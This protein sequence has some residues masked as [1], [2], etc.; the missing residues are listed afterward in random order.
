[1][2][3]HDSMGPGLQLIWARFSNFLLRKLSWEFKLRGMSVVYTIQPVAKPVW[4]PDWQSVWQPIVS[5]IQT[6]NQLSNRF[7]NRFDNRL[8]R[9][10]EPLVY[11]NLCV[12]IVFFHS[13][14]YMIW[15]HFI[16]FQLLLYFHRFSDEERDANAQCFHRQKADEEEDVFA[17]ATDAEGISY[18]VLSST[19]YN[20]TTNIAL[21]RLYVDA[22]F[23]SIG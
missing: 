1:M 18:A 9:V 11:V 16:W 7:D 13:S 20:V 3:G 4:Q 21:R 14:E 5:C 15:F 10:N 8:Y 22:G 2:V 23:I 12:L 6:F 17:S 19:S